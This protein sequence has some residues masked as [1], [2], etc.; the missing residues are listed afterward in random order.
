MSRSSPSPA[1]AALNGTGNGSDN[2][3]TGNGG[4]NRL[5]GAGGDDALNGAGGADTLNGGLGNDTLD[6]GSGLD[7]FLFDTALNSTTNV[8][9]IIDFVIADD[10]IVL[11]RGIFT[12]AGANG[13]LAA[14]AFRLGGFAQDADDRILYDPGSGNIFYDADGNGPGSA[15]LFAHVTPGLVL[16]AADFLIVP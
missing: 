3:I 9:D 5:Y 11:D 4:N 1:R 8:D 6:G 13:T 14:S 2:T 7:R 10:T 16:T 12:Q 15:L